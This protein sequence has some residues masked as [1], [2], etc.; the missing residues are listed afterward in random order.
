MCQLK[1]GRKMSLGHS[2]APGSAWLQRL[3]HACTLQ[4]TYFIWVQLSGFVFIMSHV[5]QMGR[6][7]WQDGVLALPSV[8]PWS[9]RLAWHSS[10]HPGS[11]ADC[12]RVLHLC[13]RVQKTDTVERNNKRKIIM[14]KDD[15]EL[16]VWD[17]KLLV[18]LPTRQTKMEKDGETSLGFVGLERRWRTQLWIR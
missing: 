15:S 3:S 1:P 12:S 11:R 16:K 18:K 14:N 17:V 4:H 10:H 5:T 2:Q 6:W 8:F 13:L 9:G 7:H